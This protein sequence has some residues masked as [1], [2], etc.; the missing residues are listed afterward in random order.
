M[1]DSQ[2]FGALSED[3]TCVKLC[4]LL[5]LLIYSQHAQV[6]AKTPAEEM[7][8]FLQELSGK[9]PDEDVTKV[10]LKT[11]LV[12]GS[13][14]FTHMLTLLERYIGPLSERLRQGGLQVRK[15]HK[16]DALRSEGRVN[17]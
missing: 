6:R 3:H 1:C 17:A 11:L 9:H 8:Q 12:T 7:D 10:F 5:R 13:K 15:Q 2:S 16:S 14:S 4:I